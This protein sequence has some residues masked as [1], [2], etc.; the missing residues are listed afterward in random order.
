[1]R[2]LSRSYA[3]TI[4]YPA[5]PVTT[6]TKI[7][8]SPVSNEYDRWNDP[9]LRYSVDA[10]RRFYFPRILTEKDK[11]KAQARAAKNHEKGVSV[12]EAVSRIFSQLKGIENEREKKIVFEA[13]CV[14]AGEKYIQHLHC[15]GLIILVP[16]GFVEC[17][18]LLKVLTRTFQ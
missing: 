12:G 11:I 2:R 16:M 1:M 7:K 13:R 18:H 9:N 8:R 6:I 17:F 15:L 10:I 14:L 4:L 3:T 5:P